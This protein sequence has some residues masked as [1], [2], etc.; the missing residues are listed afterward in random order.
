MGVVV[1]GLGG[2]RYIYLKLI[3]LTLQQK[4]TQ[5]CKAN[6]TP[7]KTENACSFPRVL[8]SVSLC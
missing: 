6:Y 5:H 4:L 8:D 1:G 2:R 7:V 3:Y